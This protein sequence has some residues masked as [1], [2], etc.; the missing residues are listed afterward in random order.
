DKYRKNDQTD[1]LASQIPKYKLVLMGILLGVVV[2]LSSVGAGAFGVMALVLIFPQLP[3]I[4]IIGSDVVHA[5]LLT[6]VAGLGHLLSGRWDRHAAP[7][8]LNSESSGTRRELG[9]I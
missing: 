5:V 8:M 6:L 9:A 2:T 7:M 4:R 1:S 3:L